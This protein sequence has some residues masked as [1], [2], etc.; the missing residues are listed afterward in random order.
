MSKKSSNLKRYTQ[1][2]KEFRKSISRWIFDGYQGG[3]LGKVFKRLIDKYNIRPKEQIKLAISTRLFKSICVVIITILIGIF[4]KYDPNEASIA[5]IVFDNLESIAL[6]SAGII[7]LL[8]TQDRQKRERYEAWQV[9]N[10]AL[11]KPGNGGRVQALE[12]LN[13]N[14]VDLE[15][16]AAPKADLSGINLSGGKLKRANFRGAQLN[17]ANFKET[18]LGFS[19]LSKADL[20]DVDFQGTGLVRAN[21]EGADLRNAKLQNSLLMHANLTG[22]YLNDANLQ[23]A[24]LTNA[25]LI[26]ANLTSANLKGAV[27][28]SADFTNANLSD[29]NLLEADI[30]QAK[31]CRTTLPDKIPPDLKPNRDCHILGINPETGEY[32]GKEEEQ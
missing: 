32:I 8:E 21:L 25:K 20:T 28:G 29:T 18:D 23:G 27:L 15:G 6:G 19:N 7:F 31:F 24:R 26:N 16:V 9:I 22:A 13:N 17:N 10:S 3:E 1:S 14:G 12:D 4:I 30:R 11:G 2:P 5:E